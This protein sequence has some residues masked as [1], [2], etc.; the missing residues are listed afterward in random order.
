VPLWVLR[1]MARLHTGTSIVSETLARVIQRPDEIGEF[2][3]LYWKDKRQ[4]LSAQVKKG[5][6]KAFSRFDRYQLAKYAKGGSVRLRDVMF[7]THPKPAK[8]VEPT[9]KEIA[10]DEIG[11]ADAV[12]KFSDH[13]GTWESNLSQSEGKDKKQVW[14][15]QLPTMGYLALLRNLRNMTDAG[16]DERLIRD[17][18]LLR[19][20]ADRVL[21]FRYVAAARA[22][23]RLE[24]A[25]DQALCEA[26]AEMRPLPGKTVVLVD[27]SGSMDDKMS[28][29]SDLNRM[30]AA[31]T[32]AA[33]IPGDV[34]M[35]TFSN[36]CVEVPPRRG[37]AGV[38]AIKRSQHHG[39]T[40][41]GAAVGH[42]NAITHNNGLGKAIDRLIVLT[43]EQSHDRVPDPLAKHAYVINVASNRNGVGYGRWTH[44][45]GFSEAVLRFIVEYERETS[46]SD[47]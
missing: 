2:V 33:I 4:P 20:G 16:V 39:G 40:M 18:I 34:R 41:M 30:D 35:F 6:A 37:M 14:T 24:P 17:A 5:L 44:I 10:N 1:E 46:T 31:A 47:R 19:K 12:S 21:P 26:I 15:D 22:C 13:A 9:W 38:D 29:K 28:G 7:L 3:S 27:V 23:P 45:D 36:N 25:I 8:G 43:D 42:V 11:A 32:L